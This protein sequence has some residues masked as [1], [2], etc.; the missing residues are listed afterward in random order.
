[1][2]AYFRERVTV[3][4]AGGD[5]LAAMVSFPADLQGPPETG[6]GGAVTTVLLELVRRYLE[7]RGDASPLEGPISIEVSLHR[8][9][10]LDTPVRGEV[11]PGSDEWRGRLSWRDRP[12]AEATVRPAGHVPAPPEDV[13]VAWVGPPASGLLVPAYAFCLGCGLQNPRGAQVRFAYDEAWMWRTLAPQ[14]HFRCRDGRLFPGYLA[15]VCDEL[16]WWLGALRQGECGVSNRL[17][18]TLASA[19]HGVPLLAL[20]PRRLVEST[21]PKGRMWRT[22]TFILGTDGAPVAAASV[23]FVGGPAFTRM[24][25]PGFLSEDDRSA[26][27][28]AFPRARAGTDAGEPRTAP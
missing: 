17:R 11:L 15:I 9:L 26:V 5:G 28:R 2:E 21:D 27:Q 22:E 23:Q 16:G 24:M 3:E 13:R 14:P 10:P 7:G 6:H 18:L 4:R 19:A 20:G 12:V 25:L 1:M 8:A